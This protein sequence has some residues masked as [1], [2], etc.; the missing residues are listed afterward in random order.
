M[1]LSSLAAA[2]SIPPASIA[3]QAIG[4][5]K[6]HDFKDSTAPLKVD[7]RVYSPAQLTI[8]S[9][10]A[11][12][13]QASYVPVGALGDVVR[14]VSAK[15]GP[16]NQNTA[17]L[18]QSYGVYG[19][20]YTDLKYGPNRAIVRASNSHLT[21]DIHVNGFYGEPA[22][23]LSTPEHY[24]FTLPTFVQ[25]GYS[26]EL[27]KAVDLSR[28]PFLG[29]FPAWFQRNSLNGNRK[30][31]L[32]S[33]DRRLPFVT[34]TKGEYLDAI[35]VALTRFYDAE[36]KRIAEA[37][38]G[39]PQRIARWM[40]PHEEKFARRRAV[41][42]TNREKYTARLQEVAGIWQMT[43]D[44]LLENYPDVFEGNGGSATRLPVYTI[45]RATVE[46][47]KGAPLWIV[48]TWTADLNDPVN[49]H[50]HEAVIDNFNFEYVYN[51]FFD[52][53]KVTGQPYTPRRH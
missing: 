34:L 50:L 37:E 39:D 43:P 5:M 24:Y 7:H 21:W 3:G 33:K 28:H 12:W 32:L 52:P 27:E 14:G 22:D 42:A 8:G 40:K 49:R 53:A 31:V 16:Y 35:G 36:K 9:K 47:A 45:D 41:L 10:L 15:L 11:T 18:P 20:L 19:K 48:V 1:L 6:V 2:Q 46:R 38:Q 26:D 51:Y 23:A 4:W 17:A 13:M 25:Q 29:Q 44:L 30:F